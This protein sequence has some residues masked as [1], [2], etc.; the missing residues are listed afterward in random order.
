MTK[1]APTELMQTKR[2]NLQFSCT[3][4]YLAGLDSYTVKQS[5]IK[6]RTHNYD[7]INLFVM[8]HNK[9]FAQE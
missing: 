5:K 1:S 4:Q 3:V 2:R 8:K 9:T 7:F 6:V